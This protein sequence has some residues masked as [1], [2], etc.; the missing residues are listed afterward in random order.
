MLRDDGV[1]Q[2]ADNA[3]VAGKSTCTALVPLVQTAEWSSHREPPRPNSIFVTQL[4]AAETQNP[5]T[6]GPGQAAALNAFSAY[7]TSQHRVEDAGPQAHENH[8]S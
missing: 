1:E 4:I 5:Q 8:L 7:R 3:A 6:S 2:T